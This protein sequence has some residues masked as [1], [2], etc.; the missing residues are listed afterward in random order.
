M[1]KRSKSLICSSCDIWLSTKWDL[2]LENDWHGTMP[3][4][5]LF[6]KLGIHY[7]R[8]Q[9]KVQHPRCT[10]LSTKNVFQFWRGVARSIHIAHEEENSS[11]LPHF[12]QPTTNGSDHGSLWG[13][14][15]GVALSTLAEKLPCCASACF[16][17]KCIPNLMMCLLFGFMPLVSLAHKKHVFW[18]IAWLNLQQVL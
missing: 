6:L 15:L 10:T 12:D 11:D 18:C 9:T 8:R 16:C 3:L 4:T 7:R 1:T 17:L 13:M 14:W 5:E 2:L